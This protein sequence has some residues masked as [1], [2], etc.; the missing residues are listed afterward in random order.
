[1]VRTGWSGWY[2]LS[3]DSRGNRLDAYKPTRRRDN[4]AHYISVRCCGDVA[5]QIRLGLVDRKCVDLPRREDW[6]HVFQYDGPWNTGLQEFMDMLQEVL[7]IPSPQELNGVLAL[8][9]HKVP[10]DPD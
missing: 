9:F 2:D 5:N 3:A 6:T 7:T 1:M 4:A 10:P 8:D